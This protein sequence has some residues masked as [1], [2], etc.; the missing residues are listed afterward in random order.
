MQIVLNEAY[1][2]YLKNIDSALC[3]LFKV[4]NDLLN[5]SSY[6]YSESIP[7]SINSESLP[8][9]D[10]LSEERSTESLN[11]LIILLIRFILVALCLEIMNLIKSCVCV[12]F[13]ASVGSSFRL[14]STLVRVLSL[15]PSPSTASWRESSKIKLF[16]GLQPT[17]FTSS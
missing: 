11:K 5:R 6:L 12:C 16:P 10:L 9:L 1:C 7:E 3:W 13:S 8:W 17:N 15:C 4:N 2:G 14:S